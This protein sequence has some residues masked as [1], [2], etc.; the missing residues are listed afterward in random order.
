MSITY[1]ECMSVALDMQH[2]MRMR[3]IVICGL[4]GYTIISQ[5]KR[6]DYRWGGRELLIVK[7]VFWFSLQR[8][9]EIFLILRRTERD[10]IKTVY[11]TSCEGPVSLVRFWWNCNFVDRFLKITEIWN[12]TKIRL[13]KAELF[14]ID[15]QRD[16]HDEDNSRFSHIYHERA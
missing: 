2:V 6:H 12:F 15:G 8:L 14:H 1:S 11:W 16:R 9:C 13:V 10:M 5:H 7:Y 3:H 4:L